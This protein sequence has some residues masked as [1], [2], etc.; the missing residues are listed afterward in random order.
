MRARYM[1]GRLAWVSAAAY[2]HNL[3]SIKS[4]VNC[5]AL[6]GKPVAF[7]EG[8]QGSYAHYRDQQNCLIKNILGSFPTIM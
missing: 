8:G 3:L 5:Q 6:S 2:S 1:P 4:F 7:L